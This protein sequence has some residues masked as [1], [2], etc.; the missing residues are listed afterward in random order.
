MRC[1]ALQCVAVCCSVWSLRFR[2]R[3]TGV[4]HSYLC[5]GVTRVSERHV[6]PTYLLCLIP[7]TQSVMCVLVLMLRILL[8]HIPSRHNSLIV[9]HSLSVV[10]GFPLAFRRKVPCS[11]REC[12]TIRLL[13]TTERECATIRL[14]CKTVVHELKVCIRVETLKRK[15]YVLRL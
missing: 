1:S 11:E 5:K 12:A 6:C 4:I 8:L 15:V 2:L 13:C 9:A 7:P 14:L 3:D 10:H